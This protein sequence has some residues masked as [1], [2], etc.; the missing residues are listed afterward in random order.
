MTDDMTKYMR[1]TYEMAN[2]YM[3][4]LGFPAAERRTMAILDIV[5]RLDD[6]AASVYAD[7]RAKI[8]LPRDMTAR[9]AK[10]RVEL[11]SLACEG[12]GSPKAFRNW[13]A[14]YNRPLFDEIL[15]EEERLAKKSIPP[16]DAD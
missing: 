3:D 2:Y 7:E 6:V 14:E 10:V 13:F 12:L 15:A 8:H 9:L 1:M 4:Q 5:K 16:S 11:V